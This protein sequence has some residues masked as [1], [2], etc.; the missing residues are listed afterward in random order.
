MALYEICFY[1]LECRG[2][3]KLTRIKWEVKDKLFPK[4]DE[5]EI[6]NNPHLIT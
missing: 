6:V 5:I 2:S 1:L 3:I 4:N